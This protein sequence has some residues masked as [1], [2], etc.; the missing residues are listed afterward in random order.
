[1]KGHSRKLKS[2][3]FSLIFLQVLSSCNGSDF[4]PKKQHVFKTKHSSRSVQ[5]N[6]DGAKSENKNIGNI[7]N[8][9]M[10]ASDQVSSAAVKGRPIN[11]PDYDIKNELQKESQDVPAEVQS[12]QV[13]GKR[14][15]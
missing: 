11:D 14:Y 13:Q 9:P 8:L 2:F 3:L 6:I 10:I 12:E 15:S 7:A 1:M 5:N 4:E